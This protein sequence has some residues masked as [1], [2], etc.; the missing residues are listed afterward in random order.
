MVSQF[1]TVDNCKNIYK[2]SLSL[3][4]IANSVALYFYIGPIGLLF[5][6]N[7]IAVFTNPNSKIHSAAYIGFTLYS[8]GNII[9][10]PYFY[11]NDIPLIAV[12]YTVG[13]AIFFHSNS[14]GLVLL[15]YSSAALILINILVVGKT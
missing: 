7:L 4:F 3:C 15:T 10:N 9:Y 8:L 5:L 11:P 14:I 6:I 13:T 1:S 2:L 12:M